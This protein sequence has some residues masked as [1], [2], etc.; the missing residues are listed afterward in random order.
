MREPFLAN[1]SLP[2]KGD[3]WRIKQQVF[4]LEVVSSGKARRLIGQA[5]NRTCAFQWSF[6][7]VRTQKSYYAKWMEMFPGKKRMRL[8]HFPRDRSLNLCWGSYAF[9]AHTSRKLSEVS[10]RIYIV[11]SYPKLDFNVRAFFRPGLN[12]RKCFPVSLSSTITRLGPD[13]LV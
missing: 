11:H 9:I 12:L 13:V 7:Y 10:N 4:L 5:K 3:S 1:A 8:H 2:K 6:H